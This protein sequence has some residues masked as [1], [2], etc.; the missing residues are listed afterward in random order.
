M[1]LYNALPSTTTFIAKQAGR[2]VATVTLIPDS[3]LGIPMDKIY[4]NEVD[5]LRGQGRRVSEASQLAIDNRLFPQ[6]WFSMFNFNK[7]IF[8]FKLFKLILDYAAEVEK[9]DDSCIAVNPKHQYLYKFIG[10]EKWGGLKYYGSVNNAPAVAKRLDL[11]RLEDYFRT[12]P[13]LY[14][15]FISQKTSPDVFAGKFQFSAAD[16]EYFFVKKSD[17]LAKATKEQL[18]YIKSLYSSAQTDKIFK[19]I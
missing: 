19:K 8:L 18:R 17:I 16:L 15:I 5:A 7:L 10:F 14:K 9:L 6:G 12:K 4:K 3:P 1:S 13:S 2:V 11:H